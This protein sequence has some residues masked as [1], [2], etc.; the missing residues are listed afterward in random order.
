VELIPIDPMYRLY[1]GD[2]RLEM[3]ANT[4]T[5]ARE[6][7]RFAPGSA[8]QL[9]R[10]LTKEYERL[11]CLYP[12]L[13]RDWPNLLSMVSP[14]VARALPHVGIGHSL[15]ATASD[16]FTN[17]DLRLAFS[18]QSAYLG[19]SPWECPGGFCM[20]P[21]VEHAWGIDHVRGGIHQLS[22]A[23]ARVATQLGAELRTQTEVKHL[24]VH[25]GRCRGVEL[26]N[27]SIV[28][29]D[30]VIVDADATRAM[31]RLLDEDVS[32]RFNRHHIASVEE[33]CSTFMLYLGIDTQLPLAHNTFLF[34]KDYRAEM[35]QVFHGR[36]LREDISVY[37]CNPSATDASLAPA[38]HSALYALALAPNTLA[39]IDWAREA[40][41]LR[42]RML[43]IVRERLGLDLEPH[44][45]V[46]RCLTPLEWQHSF[47]ISHGAVFG[48]AH[49]IEQLLAFRL[50][51]QLPNLSNV[52]LTGGGTSPGSGLP[53][54]L[55]SGRIAARL[56]CEQESVPFPASKP[57]P[58]PQHFI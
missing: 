57:L 27:G 40:P 4:A 34:S 54:I 46:E 37:L 29:A 36:D 48:P 42:R 10:F 14:A 56:L 41:H 51:N 22:K 44:I 19:M 30:A 23:M 35:Q 12:V 32:M 21:F 1:C 7:E 38:G 6:L 33:S 11:R 50:P 17:E 26:T 24:V 15:Y 20:V 55:E 49:S 39:H 28:E 47:G 43:S 9:Q 18:F 2:R 25:E 8:A 58:A 5:M 53:T 13:Q 52:F 45:R 16:Y 3:F 31:L